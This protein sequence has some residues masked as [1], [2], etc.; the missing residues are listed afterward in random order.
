MSKA[1]RPPW[2][3]EFFKGTKFCR[4][5][6]IALDQYVK[7]LEEECGR[8]GKECPA[9]AKLSFKSKNGVNMKIKDGVTLQGLNINMRRA[10]MAADKVYKGHGEVLTITSTTEGQHS[11]WSLHPFGLAFD[12]RTRDLHNDIAASIAKELKQ[13]LGSWG[14]DVILEA[15]HIHIEYDDGKFCETFPRN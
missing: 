12:C 10:I 5:M 2:V 11:S 4:K 9:N 1:D 13:E 14:F 8:L 6:G 15:D 3:H 7:K